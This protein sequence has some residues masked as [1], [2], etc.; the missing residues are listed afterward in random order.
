MISKYV[1]LAAACGAMAVATPVAAQEAAGEGFIVASGG[2]HSLGFEDEVQAIAPGAEIDDSSLIFGGAAGFDFTLGGNVFAGIEGN[3]HFG[4]DAL[5]SDYGASV[6]LGYRAAT[7]SKFYV[8]G[9]YQ[10][11]DVDYNQ[12]VNDDTID[13][14]GVDD[15]EGDYLVGVGVDVPLGGVFIR[16]NVDTISFDTLRA[17]AGIGVRF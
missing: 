10:Q 4:T 13:F 8:R 3:Y 5:D 15:T 9:G 7:G 17:T 16:G 6:R 11:I 1:F 12:I 14:T 2:F